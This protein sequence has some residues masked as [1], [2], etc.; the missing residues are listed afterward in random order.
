MR[1]HSE[2]RVPQ[3]GTG[4]GIVAAHPDLPVNHRHARSGGGA[5]CAGA[6]GERWF[7]SPQQPIP[8]P[9][10]TQGTPSDFLLRFA[11]ADKAACY[12]SA[13][14]SRSEGPWMLMGVGLAVEWGC[15]LP[16]TGKPSR[17]H[18]LDAPLKNLLYKKNNSSVATNSNSTRAGIE[19]TYS[20]LKSQKKSVLASILN[21]F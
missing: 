1:S 11:P 12:L 2:K 21:L 15:F 5:W 14:N 18:I 7:A 20:G 3:P 6:G 4:G 10:G 8:S 13:G 19:W 9:W 17:G 16:N